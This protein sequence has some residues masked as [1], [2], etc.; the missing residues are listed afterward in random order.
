MFRNI[1]AA[2]VSLTLVLCPAARAGD[3]CSDLLEAKR[4]NDAELLQLALNNP[5]TVA[6]LV[7]CASSVKDLPEDQQFGAFVARCGATC[8]FVVGM[9]NCYNLGAKV[10]QLASRQDEIRRQAALYHCPL[11]K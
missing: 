9:D 1:V 7:A 4:Q 10:I 8:L 2:T 3:V 5:G 6:A 11:P